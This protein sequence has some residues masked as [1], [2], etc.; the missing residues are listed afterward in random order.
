MN[1]IIHTYMIIMR[2]QRL[3]LTSGDAEFQ[4]EIL[5]ATLSSIINLIFTPAQSMRGGKTH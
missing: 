1:P 5:H 3:E 2:R 4:N